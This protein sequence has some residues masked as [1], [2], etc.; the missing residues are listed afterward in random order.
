MTIR[1]QSTH[2][3]LQYNKDNVTKDPNASNY[4]CVRSQVWD[5]IYRQDS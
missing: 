3:G 5:G 2:G 4:R 1:A